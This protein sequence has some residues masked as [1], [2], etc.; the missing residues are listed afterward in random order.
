MPLLT[1]ANST[2]VPRATLA[3]AFPDPRLRSA[4]EQ[5]LATANETPDAVNAFADATVLVAT[6]TGVLPNELVI[7]G[8]PGVTFDYSTPNVVVI[9]VTLTITPA[10]MATGLTNADDDAAAAAAGV[11]LGHLY[12]NG[13]VLQ[14]RVT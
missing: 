5:A 10:S 14:Y 1:Q 3:A 2:T 4:I 9:N 12:R 8:G 13:S 6:P 11:A 7:T